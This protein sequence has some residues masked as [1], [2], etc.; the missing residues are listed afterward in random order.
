MKKSL[1]FTLILTL[2]M[3]VLAPVYAEDKWDGTVASGF[4]KGDGTLS[5]PYLIENASQLAY[6]AT[7]DTTAQ[8]ANT[9]NKYYKLVADIDLNNI[10]WDPIM[11]FRGHFDGNGY[12]VSN[13]ML[14]NTVTGSFGLFRYN[15]GTITDLTIKNVSVNETMTSKSFGALC[16]SNSGIIEFCRITGSFVM[17]NQFAVGGITYGNS[18]TIRYSWVYNAEVEGNAKYFGGIV[19]DLHG[20]VYQ[21]G[22][23]DVNIDIE[24]D[25]V[26]V[27]GVVGTATSAT[28]S[29]VHVYNL[30]ML[31]ED[32]TSKAVSHFGGIVGYSQ[33]TEIS[34][35]SISNSSLQSCP[36]TY[37]HYF[38]GIVGELN[39]GKCTS[40]ISDTGLFISET[41]CTWYHSVGGIAGF[42]TQSSVIENSISR[43]SFAMGVSSS[44]TGEY[45][46]NIG[47][48]CGNNG[49]WAY[50]KNCVND[51][52]IN[53]LID[54]SY[55]GYIIGKE[56][57]T[58]DSYD[59]YYKSSNALS[60]GIATSQYSGV[61]VSNTKD[62]DFLKNTVGL[63]EYTTAS[64]DN[65]AVWTYQYGT[66]PDIYSMYNKCVKFN[67]NGGEGEPDSQFIKFLSGN[68]LSSQ[69]PT[70]ENYKFKQWNTKA[71]G[72]G[73]SYSAGQ[74]ISSQY[75][76]GFIKL[77]AIWEEQQPGT[78]TT[79][80]QAQGYKVCTVQATDIPENADI[81]VAFYEG[82]KLLFAKALDESLTVNI[83]D[84]VVY[85][86]VKTF[87]WDE[88]LRPIT[89]Q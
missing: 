41:V 57:S 83:S 84:N 17:G 60:G 77:Y 31:V 62:H 45:A 86:N 43:C 25:C 21:C 70:R 22:V 15:Y 36:D 88:N 18:G 12:M 52:S 61:A 24:G 2:I 19:Y 40:C 82:K 39:G 58:T 55:I 63:C 50:V 85:D 34:N 35:C 27:G 13:L 14:G 44:Y 42:G 59:C 67:S 29:D 48:I 74:D 64:T 65:L 56:G 11:Y 73:T 68:T 89:R 16:Y 7:L 54:T 87:V 76:S 69:I 9:K 79:I 49:S 80:T 30:S 23:E 81:I 4:S 53:S 32:F 78:V 5:S 28:I 10:A 72:T 33:S 6:L 3:S 8:T 46:L 47:G 66:Y 1:I 75:A 20:E 38:G 71:D 37:I 26:N 51:S